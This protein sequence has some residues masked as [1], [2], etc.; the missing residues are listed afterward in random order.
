MEIPVVENKLLD[1]AI[2]CFIRYGVK[3]TSMSDIAKEAGVSRPTLY[4]SFK[5]KDE[6]L[7]EVI[8]Y[9]TKQGLQALQ[10]K[11]QQLDGLSAKLDAYFETTIIASYDL[12]QQSPDAEDLQHGFSEAGRAAVREV[13]FWSRDALMEIFLP[14]QANIE[15]V[16][17]SVEQFAYFVVCSAKGAKQM[18]ASREELLGLLASLK[19]VVLATTSK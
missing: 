8:R 17:Q 19:A 9:V 13:S 16:G 4:A 7:A 14:Y 18:A 10:A 5:N 6:M 11:W 3:K 2:N 12:V 15:Q 1:A